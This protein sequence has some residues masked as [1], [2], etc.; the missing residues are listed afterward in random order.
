MLQY[1]YNLIRNFKGDFMKKG[2]NFNRHAKGSSIKVQPIK[3]LKNI[4]TIK[5]LLA[6]KPLDYALF[7]IGI[8]TNLRASD[9]LRIKVSQV[10]HLQPHEE[11]V[12]NGKK[13]KKER[14]IKRRSQGKVTNL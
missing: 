13:T 9:L 6:H 4:K 12:L 5:K 10:R 7:V 11:I 8:N 14:R 2:Q 1:Y 3:S